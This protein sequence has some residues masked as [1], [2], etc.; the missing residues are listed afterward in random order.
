MWEIFGPVIA[1]V[2]VVSATY[3]LRRQDKKDKQSPF[4]QRVSNV[5]RGTLEDAEE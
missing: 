4:G 3:L 2:I 1:A 5:D